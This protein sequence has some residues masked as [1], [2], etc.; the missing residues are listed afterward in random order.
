MATS[1]ASTVVFETNVWV[2]KCSSTYGKH[3]SLLAIG[4]CI[5]IKK[6]P[7]VNLSYRSPNEFINTKTLTS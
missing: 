7:I 1:R 2:E 4:G 5:T 6:D 3:V